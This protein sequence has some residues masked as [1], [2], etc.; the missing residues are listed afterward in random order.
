MNMH[1]RV[2][3]S[4]VSC[5][6]ELAGKTT[7]SLIIAENC[8]VVCVFMNCGFTHASASSSTHGQAVSLKFLF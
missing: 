3:K 4:Y 8:L 6:E 1:Q 5:N 2:R 7:A